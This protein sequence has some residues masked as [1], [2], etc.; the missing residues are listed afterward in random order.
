[1]RIFLY[2]NILFSAAKSDGAVSQ[3]LPL[4]RTAGHE[5]CADDYV[6]EEA[7]RNLLA[8]APDR[9][10][11]LERLL[12]LVKLANARSPDPAP[13][14][15]LPLPAKD[16]PVLAAAI[17]QGCAALVTGDRTHFGD[18]YGRTIHGVTVHSPRSLAEALLPR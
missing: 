2:A 1:M 9:I 5:C 16:R 4:L 8:K 3:L 12:S 6:V 17:H 7:R 11:V 13:E 15:S 18:L 10:A 14:A